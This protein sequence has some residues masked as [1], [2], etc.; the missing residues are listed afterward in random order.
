[1]NL[2]LVSQLRAW[3]N[4]NRG[5]LASGFISISDKLP[6]K[7]DNEQSKGCVGLTKGH[8]LVS[9]TAWD[10]APFPVE[11][12]VYNTHLDTTVVMADVLLD[13]LDDVVTKLT[14]TSNSLLNG[15]YDDMKPDSDISSQ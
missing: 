9:F 15:F 5:R 10:R 13:K 7:E 11:L 8:I 12:L 1:M 2:T 14:I 6:S 3:I 4:E